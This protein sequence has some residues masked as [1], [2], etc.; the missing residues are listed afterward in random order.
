MFRSISKNLTEY[1]NHYVDWSRIGELLHSGKHRYSKSELL[2]RGAIIASTAISAFLGAY[3]NDE[4]KTGYSDG[5]ATLAAGIAGFVL[6]HTVV[7]VPI[8]KKRYDMSSDCKKFANEI[9]LKMENHPKL[10]SASRQAINS[11][12]THISK[13]SLS[14]EKHGKASQTWG[15]RKKILSLLNEKLDDINLDEGIWLQDPEVVLKQLTEICI[16]QPKI[17]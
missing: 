16:S 2:V 11:L 12:V 13:I 3:L 7:I 4:E 8:L 17:Q 14:D 1:C 10:S 5:S 6:S 15:K 9:T